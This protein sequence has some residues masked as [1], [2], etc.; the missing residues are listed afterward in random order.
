MPTSFGNPGRILALGL[1]TSFVGLGAAILTAGRGT[2]PTN[3]ERQPSIAIKATAT[4]PL[5]RI[6]Q[7]SLPS[8][9]LTGFRLMPL[10]AYSLDTRV[11]LAQRATQSLDVQY[12]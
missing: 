1:R 5:V 2:L 9:E 7:D 10:G 12:Y 3:V 11:A 8:P 6:A 4:S